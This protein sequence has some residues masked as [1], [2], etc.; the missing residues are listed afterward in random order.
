MGFPEF[1][2]IFLAAIMLAVSMNHLFLAFR[3]KNPHLHTAIF[4][5]GVAGFTY[6]TMVY[7]GYSSEPI[8]SH[9]TK[10]YRYQLLFMQA[11]FLSLI[12]SFGLLYGPYVK[13]WMLGMLFV[14]GVLIITTL[15][16]PDSYLFT[17]NP[18]T[19]F[20]IVMGSSLTFLNDGIIPWRILV[21]LTVIA[22]IVF[23]VM[24]VMRKMLRHPSNQYYILLAVTALLLFLGIID[25]LTDSGNI[26]AIYL[27]PI[28]YFISYSMLSSSSL[29][30]M[31]KDI[32]KTNELA[33]EER[34]WRLMVSEIKLMVVVLNTLGQI[35]FVNP[36]LLAITG[37][38]EDELIGKD[39]FELLLPRSH[40]YEVQSAFIEILTNDFHSHYENPI[41]TKH[42]EEKL[43][44]WFNVRLRDS[45]GKI[46]GSISIGLDI[47]EEREEKDRLEKELMAANE[48]IKKLQDKAD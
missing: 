17:N 8:T 29:E 31:V 25:H 34:K 7:L 28:G 18:S 26:N 15:V 1:L 11:S 39:W 24:I 5:S 36:Y 37:Y 43:I 27:L 9:V 46:S 33:I 22:T 47:S 19:A 14:F 42:H 6:L 45:N 30:Q 21:D 16:I 44:S 20:S 38:E 3:I 48:L 13:K 32:R 4:L 40:A 35:K 41:L 23:G 12:W 10:I 2:T